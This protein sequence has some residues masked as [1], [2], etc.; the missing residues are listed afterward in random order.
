MYFVVEI[1]DEEFDDDIKLQMLRSD[2]CHC[3]ITTLEDMTDTEL[4]NIYIR[5]EFDV[6]SS[7]KLLAP[8][9]VLK[10]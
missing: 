6:I 9:V 10:R 3:S 5:K 2:V 1:P 8:G 7:I 4:A